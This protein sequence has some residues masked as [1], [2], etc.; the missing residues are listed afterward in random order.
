MPKFSQPMGELVHIV[1]TGEPFNP[2]EIVSRCWAVVRP[3]TSSD[4][5][6]QCTQVRKRWDKATQSAPFLCCPWHLGQEFV[7]RKWA[8]SNAPSH[9]AVKQVRRVRLEQ[10]ARKH[11]VHANDLGEVLR[12]RAEAR[13]RKGE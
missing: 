11:R 4:A 7:A 2:P 13:K 10:S 12:R 8:E 5:A 9:P 3:R 1:R 6:R